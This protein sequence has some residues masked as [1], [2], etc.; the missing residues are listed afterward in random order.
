MEQKNQLTEYGKKL[1]ALRK[2]LSD[3]VKKMM[4]SDEEFAE[5]LEEFDISITVGNQQHQLSFNSDL[6]TDLLT[7]IDNQIEDYGT[8]E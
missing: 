2:D 5:T 1:M 4:D 8:E 6:Y 3:N 7:M